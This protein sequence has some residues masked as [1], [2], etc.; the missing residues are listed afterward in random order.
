MN[1]H[2]VHPALGLAY[3]RQRELLAHARQEQQASRVR[4]LQRAG[5]RAERAE[6]QLT[7]ALNEVLRMRSELN[8]GS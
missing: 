7:H 5:R 6:H 4:K 3:E 2:L 8:W 1:R